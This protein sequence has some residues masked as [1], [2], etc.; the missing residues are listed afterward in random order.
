[1]QCVLSVLLHRGSAVSAHWAS[2]QTHDRCNPACCNVECMRLSMLPNLSLL[3]RCSETSGSFCDCST[4][5]SC[6]CFQ[7][8]ETVLLGES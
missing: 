7:P 1:M 3:L 6:W 5:V 4:A 2:G 8:T